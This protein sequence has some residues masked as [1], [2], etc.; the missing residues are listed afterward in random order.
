M[1][2][3]DFKKLGQLKICVEKHLDKHNYKLMKLK[4]LSKNDYHFNKLRAAFLKQFYWNKNDTIKIGF[5]GD[6]N[7]VP[8]NTYQ[9]LI[10]QTD[11]VDPLQKEIDKM[12]IITGIKTIINKR[13]QPIVG[14]KFQFVDNYKDADIRIS[15]DRNGAAWSIIGTQCKELEK[16]QPT[17]NLGWFDVPTTLHEFGHVLGLIHEH[18]NSNENPI[19]WNKK[20]V[21]EWA[22]TSQG[23]D[24]ATTD[25]NILNKYDITQINGSKFDPFSI[26]LYF[27]PAYLT[28]NNEGT[29]QN[30]KLS[31]YDVEYI[32]KAY[33]GGLQSP[34]EF[35]KSAYNEDIN[36]NILLSDNIRNKE[37]NSTDNKDNSNKIESNKNYTFLFYLSIILIIGLIVFLILYFKNKN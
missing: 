21:Y 32:S 12:D 27:Y 24:K 37:L 26:M 15:F 7:Y 3:D 28:I 35:Y 6:P 17:M 9:E 23:W 22:Q 16:D 19:L 11:N 13:I 18:Q 20:N 2:I 10:S 25:Q 5:I 36:K 4:E 1:N 29:K 8:R 33:P 14:L 30:Y 34:T 31:G